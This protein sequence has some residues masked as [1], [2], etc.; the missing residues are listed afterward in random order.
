MIYFTHFNKLDPLLKISWCNTIFSDWTTHLRAVLNLDLWRLKTEFNFVY[1]RHSY[2][3]SN[4]LEKI[5][6]LKKKLKIFKLCNSLYEVTG[7]LRQ[8]TI[9]YFYSLKIVIDITWPMLLQGWECWSVE[10]L[11]CWS[12]VVLECWSVK[13]LECWSVGVL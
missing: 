2:S 6:E 9:W 11:E 10:V 8:L 4:Y 5:L 7:G 1:Q 12:V 13:V 3:P